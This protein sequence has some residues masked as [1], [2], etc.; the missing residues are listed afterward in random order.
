MTNQQIEKEIKKLKRQISCLYPYKVYT[1]LLTQ[2]GTDAPVATVLQNTLGG[3]VV[4]TRDDVG[5]YT[6]TLSSAFTNNKTI[7]FSTVS[8]TNP[9]IYSALVQIQRASDNTIKVNNYYYEPAD[10]FYLK[11]ISYSG[12]PVQIEIRVYY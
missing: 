4:W 2:S 9:S 1:A 8:I 12:V 3:T 11:D 10:A 7:C 5:D 6:A